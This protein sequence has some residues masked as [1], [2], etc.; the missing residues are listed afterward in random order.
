[1][2]DRVPMLRIAYWTGAVLDA[3]SAFAMLYS[4]FYVSVNLADAANFVPGAEYRYAMAHG[5]ALMIGWTVLLIWADRKP[6]ERRGVLIITAFPVVVG[7]YLSRWVLFRAGMLPVAFPLAGAILP[8][9]L[10]ILFVFAYVNS[11]RRTE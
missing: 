4:P 2:L 9:L 1:M 8:A 3:L 11:L 5:A 7:L 6:L 10:C